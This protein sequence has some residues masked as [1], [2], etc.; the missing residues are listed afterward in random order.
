MSK[1]VIVRDEEIH[2]TTESTTQEILARVVD[3]V[4]RDSQESPSEFL[5][6][7]TVPHGGE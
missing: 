1:E 2:A 6:E 4:R 7:T 3:T 5:S